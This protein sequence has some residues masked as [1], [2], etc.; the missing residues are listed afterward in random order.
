M[1]IENQYI[2]G[3]E[4]G[5]PVTAYW[6]GT[7]YVDLILIPTP[8]CANEIPRGGASTSVTIANDQQWTGF[9]NSLSDTPKS[10]VEIRV[11]LKPSELNGWKKSTA[12]TVGS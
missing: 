10:V 5:P 6:V 11:I 12:M 2:I 7:R 4:V 8:V 1:G 9:K 3:V